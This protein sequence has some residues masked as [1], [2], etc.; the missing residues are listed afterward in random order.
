MHKR[1]IS[2]SNMEEFPEEWE[3]LVNVPIYKKSEV[4]VEAHHFCQLITDCYP[5]SGCQG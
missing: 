3:G 4:T 5:T 2:I 1:I